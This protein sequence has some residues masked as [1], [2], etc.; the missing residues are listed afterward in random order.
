M[1]IAAISAT[2]TDTNATSS[3]DFW[4]R[5]SKKIAGAQIASSAP[6]MIPAR[7]ENSRAAAHA[8]STADSEPITAW[9]MRTASRSWPATA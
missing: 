2:A 8:T 7:V 5:P 4:I 1:R 9:T 6:A 3:T